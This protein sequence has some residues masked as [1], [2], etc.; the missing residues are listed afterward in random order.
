MTKFPSSHFFKQQFKNICWLNVKIRRFSLSLMSLNEVFFGFFWILF[1]Q[2]KQFD[3]GF[4]ETVMSISQ[5][6]FDILID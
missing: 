5:I 3:F 4:W 2:K 6:S 1:G